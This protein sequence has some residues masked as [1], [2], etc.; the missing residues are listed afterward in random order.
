MKCPAYCFHYRP[1]LVILSGSK[2]SNSAG[3]LCR[4]MPEQWGVPRKKQPSA[5]G[6]RLFPEHPTPRTLSYTTSDLITSGSRSRTSLLAA[7]WPHDQRYY[8][9]LNRFICCPERPVPLWVQWWCWFQS[10]QNVKQS[11]G[12]GEFVT[13]SK[14]TNFAT[15]CKYFKWLGSESI[16]LDQTEKELFF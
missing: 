2:I 13:Y 15:N 4:V 11:L 1:P 3:A 12:N 16:S 8:K 7:F 9:K 5:L 6:M 14:A 10:W